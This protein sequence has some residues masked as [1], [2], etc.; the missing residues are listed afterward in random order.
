MVQIEARSLELGYGRRTVLPDVNLRDR[1]G[2][3]V[4]IIGP[5]GAGKSTLLMSFNAVVSIFGGELHV[6][7]EPVHR[8]SNSASSSSLP[9]RDHLPGLQ[10]RQAAH[11]GGQH[12]RGMLGRMYLLPTMIKYYTSRSTTDL[13]VHAHR[14]H[15]GRGPA[16]LR[17]LSGGRCSAWPSPGPWPRSPRSSWPTSPFRR[18]TP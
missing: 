6:L 15:R 3:F 9:H 17:P 5:S 18:S 4:G 8:I 13:G 2:E 12:R 7:G 14:R 11:G 16:T 1:K 10:P